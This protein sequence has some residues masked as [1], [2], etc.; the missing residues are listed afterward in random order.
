MIFRTVL[1]QIRRA[2]YGI[3]KI[4][5]VGNTASSKLFKKT[6]DHHPEL[7]YRIVG[8][9]TPEITGEA[10][11]HF[12]YSTKT[13]TGSIYTI[14]E[15]SQA[16]HPEEVVFTIPI[17]KREELWLLI[18]TF[19]KEGVE[20]KIV[21]DIYEVFFS[22]M[23]MEDL[24]GVPMIRFRPVSLQVMVHHP[25]TLPLSLTSRWRGNLGKEHR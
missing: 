21:P 11:G 12:T 1:I 18:N 2:G 22:R 4:L 6:I 10:N 17:G 24:E 23:A 3:R 20:V 25:L 14:M 8:Y 13:V 15:E 7:G 9:L 19:Q 5:I 16:L